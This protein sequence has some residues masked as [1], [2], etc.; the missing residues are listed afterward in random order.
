M[1]EWN[2]GWTLSVGRLSADTTEDSV[3]GRGKCLGKAK[4]FRVFKEFLRN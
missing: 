3:L 4:E 1:E 2:F